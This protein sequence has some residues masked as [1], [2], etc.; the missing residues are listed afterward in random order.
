MIFLV[1]SPWLRSPHR[2]GIIKAM[3]LKDAR[4]FD[5]RL[6]HDDVIIS[7]NEAW[8]EF[9]REN[10]AFGLIPDAVL[11]KPL[12]GFIADMETRHLYRLIYAVVREEQR[13]VV[14]PFRCDS[15]D[16]R[17]FME[18]H[19]IGADGGEVQTDCHILR[20]EAREPV[21]L[22]EPAA[23]RDA[24]AFVTIC[25]WCKRIKDDAGQWAEVEDAVRRLGL[26]ER[27]PLPQL[28]HGICPL[29]KKLIFEKV[30]QDMSRT[31]NGRGLRPPM[32]RAYA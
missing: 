16:T 11:N 13:Q 6:N 26:M 5:Y 10:N 3:I 25:S 17:R 23:A 18:M 7:V 19:I 21:E 1:F 9:A 27:Q 31:V 24:H 12:W 28:T 20:M 32:A 15:P 4:S 22:L 30:A 8:Y 29:C 2:A 14:I